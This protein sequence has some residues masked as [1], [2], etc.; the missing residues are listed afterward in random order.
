METPTITSPSMRKKKG[1]WPTPVRAI[2]RGMRR[3]GASQRDIVHKTSLPRRTIRRILSQE[4]SRRDRVKNHSRPHLLSSRTIRQIIRHISRNWSTRIMS[5]E[6]VRIELGFHPSARTI[7]RALA[8]AGYRRCI[9]CP[10]PYITIAQAR[11]RVAFAL[12]HRWWGTTDYAAHRDDGLLGGDWR[13]VIWSDEATF[14]TGKRGRMW[15][16]RRVDERRCPDCIKSIYRSGRTSVMLWSALGWD[17]KSELVFIEKLPERK[18]VC[19]KAYLQE[20]LEPVI[21]P[22]FDALG[23]E[24]IFMEDGAKVHAGSARLSRLQHNIRGFNWPPSSPDRN[25]IEKVWR[26]MKEELKKLP[27][28]PKSKEAL[29]GELQKLWDQV[30]PRD[31]RHYTAQLTCKLEDVIE[32]RGMSTVN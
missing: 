16:T 24:Y 9:S 22:L 26:W 2:I 29:R 30:D 6:R 1:E 8:L 4:S 5:F 18:G 32:A 31:Y 15:V 10:R 19:S 7:R 3:D 23:P 11:R 13:N 21:L 28:V 20:V 14:E 17:Y 25:P 12:E 27:N